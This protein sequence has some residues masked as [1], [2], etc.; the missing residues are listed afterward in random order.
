MLSTSAV[1][2]RSLS[3]G[4][5]ISRILRHFHVLLTE[6]VYVETKKL[7]KEII[8]EIG[9]HW[10]Q[11]KWVNVKSSKNEEILVASDNDRMLND[12]YSKDELPDF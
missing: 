9:F 12:V 8:S 1:T 5:I 7:G 2:N 6:P 11:G 10:R 4:S 3:Y